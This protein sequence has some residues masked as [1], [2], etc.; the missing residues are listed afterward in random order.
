MKRDLVLA[1][2]FSLAT[3]CLLL[4]AIAGKFKPLGFHAGL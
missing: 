2:A 4:A 3:F 1:R